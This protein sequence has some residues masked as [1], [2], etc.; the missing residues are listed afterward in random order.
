[1]G[2]EGVLEGSEAAQEVLFTF[3][4]AADGALTRHE[5]PVRLRNVHLELH[6]KEGRALSRLSLEIAVFCKLTGVT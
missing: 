5:L 6:G 2:A 4:G 1:V 3:S